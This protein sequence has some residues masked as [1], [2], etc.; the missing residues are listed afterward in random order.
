VDN[1]VVLR[2]DFNEKQHTHKMLLSV[3]KARGGNPLREEREIIIGPGGVEVHPLPRNELDLST[4]GSV[5][6]LYELLEKIKQE[7]QVREHSSQ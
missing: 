1:I 3:M 7:I 6:K 5:E 2:Q 4:F